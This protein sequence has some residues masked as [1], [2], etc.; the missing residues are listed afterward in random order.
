M[1]ECTG[2]FRNC[3]GE[4]GNDFIG[5]A[6]LGLLRN[7]VSRFEMQL[8]SKSPDCFL[9]FPLLNIVGGVLNL[10]C[11]TEEVIGISDPP[12]VCRASREFPS[13]LY[14]VVPGDVNFESRIFLI[15]E[16][17]SNELKL[18]QVEGSDPKRE[19]LSDRPNVLK[20][21]MSP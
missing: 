2:E 15:E 14:P 20:G 12:S 5:V 13:N 11:I 19:S 7:V 1:L 17:L 18:L 6:P 16:V 3:E 21:D 10:V 4:N 8:V 9:F